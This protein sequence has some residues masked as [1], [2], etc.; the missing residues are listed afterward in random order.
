MPAVTI[1][2][3]FNLKAGGTL[4]AVCRAFEPELESDRSITVPYKA[5][6]V[7]YLQMI[8][9]SPRMSIDC[10]TTFRTGGQLVHASDVFRFASGMIHAVSTV[11]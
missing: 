2:G 1:A 4:H 8:T 9:A 5:K 3:E 11:G 10:R 7:G 6:R